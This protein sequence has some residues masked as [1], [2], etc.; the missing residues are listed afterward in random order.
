M[1]AFRFQYPYLLHGLWGILILIVFFVYVFHN[2]EKL[3][4]RLGHLEMLRKMMPGYSKSRAVWKSVLFILSYT[5]LITALA[6]P[7]IGTKLEDVKREGVDIIIALDVSKSMDAR[8][9]VPSRLEKAKH[10]IAKLIDLLQGDRIGLVA[11]SGIA[12]IQ[13]PLTLDYSAAK[14][15]L[16]MMDTQLIPV[17]GTAIGLGIKEAMKGF[18]QKEHKHKVLILITDGE[19]HESEPI[20]MAEE[21]AKE[22]VV[23][24]TIGIGSQQGVPIPLFDGS[25]N[26]TGYKKDRN[27]NVITTK[28]DVTA[29]QK[30]AFLTNGKYYISSSGEAELKDIYEEINKMEKKEL[31]SKKFSHYED[32]FQIFIIIALIF[33]IIE[34]FLPLRTKRGV[35]ELE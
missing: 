8:D 19:D 27:D 25:G 34:I 4:Q 7:Q 32:R 22:G 30:A 20:K 16:Q 18:S 3:L 9:I 10:E 23:I 13:C 6:D 35:Y 14:L 1:E 26:P 17:P 24:Y 11:F 21:A 2:K 29:L 15:F 31:G 12:H 5:F 33:L 28:L